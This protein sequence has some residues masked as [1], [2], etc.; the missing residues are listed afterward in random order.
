MVRRA[1]LAAMVAMVSWAAQAEH[2]VAPEAMLVPAV[3]REVCTESVWGF[4][5]IRT[6]CRFEVRAAPQPN[7]ALKGICTTYY[8]LRE[9][10]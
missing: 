1:V 3:T 9:C 10:H 2:A 4:D 6:D 8:G 5:E 7:P